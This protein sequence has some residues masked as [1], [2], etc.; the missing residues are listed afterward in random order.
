M[1]VMGGKVHIHGKQEV[2]TKYWS[3]SLMRKVNMENL[4]GNMIFKWI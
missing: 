3:E 1:I 2:L 4:D